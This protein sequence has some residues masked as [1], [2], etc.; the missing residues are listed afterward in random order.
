MDPEFLSTL[1][2]G[3][4]TNFIVDCGDYYELTYP[5]RSTGWKEARKL[6]IT[7][8]NFAQAADLSPYGSSESLLK[9]K[10]GLK[11]KNFSAWT[12]RIMNEGAALEDHVKEYYERKYKKRVESRD[13]IIPKSYPYIGVSVDGYVRKT[14]SIIEIKCPQ[15]MYSGLVEAHYQKKAG[16]VFPRNYYD[17]IK[18]DHYCQMQGGMAIL[19][20]EFCDYVVYC[21]NENRITCWRIYRNR[22][23]WD[24][25]LFPKLKIFVNN[26]RARTAE[27]A[28]M[29]NPPPVIPERSG[30]VQTGHPIKE[31]T[32]ISV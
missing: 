3:F 30:D 13:L 5:Q 9:E 14:N 31:E 10:L 19:N 7:A 16:K 27:L 8:S 17:H 22:E 21:Q 2:Q 23:F 18:I 4:S 11:D 15:T 24:N 1:P 29:R 6:R 32:S 12:Q 28:V 26:L 25:I 20:C